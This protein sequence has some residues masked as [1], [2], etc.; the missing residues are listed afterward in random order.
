MLI[1]G[2]GL[3]INCRGKNLK[4]SKDEEKKSLD[5]IIGRIMAL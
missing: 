4:L 2:G 5:R 1:M 3:M